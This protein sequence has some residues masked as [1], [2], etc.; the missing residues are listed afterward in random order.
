MLGL[1]ARARTGPC[2]AT[3][4]AWAGPA[5]A[6][7]G[8]PSADRSSTVMSGNAKLMDASDQAKRAALG[9]PS[10]RKLRTG[11]SGRANFRCVQRVHHL[12]R[13][14]LHVEDETVN[15]ADEVVVRDVDRDRD[16]QT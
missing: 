10:E 1:H 2:S 3:A 12:L 15:A 13:C 5:E 9:R 8:R 16:R 14:L 11:R 7:I 4:D 6:G